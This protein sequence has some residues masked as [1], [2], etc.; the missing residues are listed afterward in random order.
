MIKY[1]D[2]INIK[3]KN[4]GEIKP[5]E[6]AFAIYC[7]SKGIDL[8]TSCNYI[9]QQLLMGKW[10][11]KDQNINMYILDSSDDILGLVNN[12]SYDKVIYIK[13]EEITNTNIRVNNFSKRY[14]FKDNFKPSIK[15]PID[16]IVDF[17]IYGCYERKLDD[18]TKF[19]PYCSN[20]EGNLIKED[21]F[22]RIEDIFARENFK[23][24]IISSYYLLDNN[25]HSYLGF[26]YNIIMNSS[27]KD[28]D[29]INIINERLKSNLDVS[30]LKK[31]DR[32]THVD[33]IREVFKCVYAG[34]LKNSLINN[35]KQLLNEIEN[36]LGDYIMIFSIE[37]QNSTSK[38]DLKIV[39]PWYF[40]A[41]T[42]C[43][44]Y[45]NGILIV[46]YGSDE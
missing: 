8:T 45:K 30:Q 2:K 3:Y 41:K 33:A 31:Y 13:C 10:I 11:T 36:K 38:Q 37:E 23:K 18:K 19:I 27:T 12:D 40:N 17:V 9:Y 15:F 21:I 20:V 7:N 29:I 46:S 24:H 35:L 42:W 4:A 22:I 43:I 5:D 28:D 34:E 6:I 14:S 32:A 1:I 39:S 25:M 44:V 26:F 16:N